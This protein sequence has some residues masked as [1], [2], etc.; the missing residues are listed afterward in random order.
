MTSKIEKFLRKLSRKKRNEI[1]ERIT[2]IILLEW[3]DLKIKKL[4][5]HTDIYRDKIGN[6]RIIFTY[7]D[8]GVEIREIA[9]RDEN[10]YKKY[11]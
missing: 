11:K 8:D 1:A 9:N 10:T 5:G 2:K 4:Q 3:R 6:V 7:N